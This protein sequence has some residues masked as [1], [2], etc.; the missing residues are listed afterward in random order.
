[1]ELVIKIVLA[2]HFGLPAFVV[3]LCVITLLLTLRWIFATYR[4]QFPIKNPEYT[5]STVGR[6]GNIGRTDGINEEIIGYIL[7]PDGKVEVFY[8]DED[9]RMPEL[10]L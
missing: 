9:E 5:G 3:V 1:M 7:N 6:S 10:V 4:S 2:S 8:Y